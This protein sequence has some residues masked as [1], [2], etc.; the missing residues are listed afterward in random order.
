MEPPSLSQHGH[1]AGKEKV[2]QEEEEGAGRWP[3]AEPGGHEVNDQHGEESPVA[4]QKPQADS[5]LLNLPHMPLGVWAALGLGHQGGVGKVI[6]AETAQ[7]IL[8]G[9]EPL[10]L[11]SKLE[12]TKAK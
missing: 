11:A 10:H 3:K 8:S 7:E 12:G 9:T 5:R 2:S 1:P 6:A 4:G